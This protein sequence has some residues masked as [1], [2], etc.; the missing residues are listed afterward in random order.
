MAISVLGLVHTKRSKTL[1]VLVV[2][3]F[4]VSVQAWSSSWGLPLS[5][6]WVLGRRAVFAGPVIQKNRDLQATFTNRHHSSLYK[7]A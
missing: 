6:T 1:L 5:V 2:T 3:A 4:L 7:N